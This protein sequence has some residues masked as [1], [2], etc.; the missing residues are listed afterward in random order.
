M[1]DLTNRTI[2]DVLVEVFESKNLWII[3]ICCFLVGLAVGAILMM[4]YFTKIRY[5]SLKNELDSVKATLTQAENER[6][7]YKAKFED[8]RTRIEELQ[9]IEFA[10][11][12][13]SSDPVPLPPRQN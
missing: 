4:L 7:E 8:A 13:I 1:M 11:L 3:I 5:Y 12:A 10:H 9:S 6:N 2:E